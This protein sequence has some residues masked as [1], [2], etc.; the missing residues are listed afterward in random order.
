MPV[1]SG[2]VPTGV[3]AGVG[4][5]TLGS[6]AMMFTF[7]AAIERRPVLTGGA[8][9]S[10]SIRVPAPVLLTTRLAGCA[11][12]FDHMQTV[13]QPHLCFEPFACESRVNG[14]RFTFKSSPKAAPRSP[15]NLVGIVADM[16]REAPYASSAASNVGFGRQGSFCNSD[17]DRRMP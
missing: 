10:V 2:C 4:G 15:R 8:H 17:W 7:L 16:Q 5:V 1:A 6:A 13:N 3:R 12:H 9:L 14:Q 11:P